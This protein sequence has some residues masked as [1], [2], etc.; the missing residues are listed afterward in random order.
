MTGTIIN[1]I[2]IV[3][4]SILGALLRKGIKPKYQDTLFCAMGLAALVIGMKAA[5]TYLPQS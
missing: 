5:I 4:G 1:T 2:A 3:A